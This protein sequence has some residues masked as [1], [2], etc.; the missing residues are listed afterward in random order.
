MSRGEELFSK[1]ALNIK[2]LK[3]MDSDELL[4]TIEINLQELVDY[5]YEDYHHKEERDYRT[6][7]TNLILSKKCFLKPLKKIIK[8]SDEELPEGLS[9][10][11][12][13]TI[14]NAGRMVQLKTNDIN[15]SNISQEDKDKAIEEMN[16]EL[17]DARESIYE[18]LYDLTKKTCKKL[19][20]IGF[21]GS[22]AYMI[23]PALFS[24]QYVSGK[25]MF[26]FTRTLTNALYT[27]Y[28]ASLA[29]NEDDQMVTTAGADLAD[30][31]VIAAVM[32]IIT[33]EMNL[34]DYAEFVKQ[35]L[36]E[37]RDKALD[38][39]EKAL[40]VYSAITTW[41]LSVLES[42]RVFNKGTRKSVI[43]SF[44]EQRTRDEKRGIDAKRRISFSE[45]DPDM[46]PNIVKAF[47]KVVNKDTD[48]D[49]D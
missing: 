36:L 49:K 26:R 39:V 20:K 18:L 37:K 41:C 7:F 27:A 30:P 14:T 33:K 28:I 21:K 22:Y 48:D 10:M 42:K 35:I 8:K 17:K 23:A 16:A 6:A 43:Q 29:K 12:Y 45:L 15:H 1:E 25:N 46:Y 38:M 32:E 19:K 13:E 34:G 2:S 3:K 47:N 9:F 5:F 4:S 11:M 40:P 24:P 44:G 31:K